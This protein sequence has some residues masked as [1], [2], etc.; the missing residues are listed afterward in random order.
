MIL[1]KY[2]IFCYDI[3][4]M[5][6][7]KKKEKSIKEVQV[8]DKDT[9]SPEVQVSILTKRITLKSISAQTIYST[10]NI[11]PMLP[12]LLLAAPRTIIRRLKLIIQAG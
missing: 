1:A 11:S 7:K 12:S 5:L 8:H 3:Q 10:Q 4:V 9:G 2:V 6:T